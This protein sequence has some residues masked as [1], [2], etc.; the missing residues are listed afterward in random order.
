MSEFFTRSVSRRRGHPWFTDNF[1]AA[2]SV[3]RKL[4]VKENSCQARAYLTE[5]NVT[6]YLTEAYLNH[7]QVEIAFRFC[8]HSGAGCP[9]AWSDGLSCRAGAT[10]TAMT[11]HG[12]CGTTTGSQSAGSGCGSNGITFT[13]SN[14]SF[15]PFG[16]LRSPN[17]N[18]N[19]TT[20]FDFE[21]VVLV[22]TNTTATLGTFTGFNTEN[23]TA[24]ATTLAGTWTSGDLADFLKE[25]S[26][27]G[28]KNPISAVLSST[29]TVDAGATGYTVSVYD[30][31]A[32]TFGSLTDPYFTFDGGTSLSTG[33]LVMGFL[34]CD[35]PTAGDKNCP[36]PTAPNTTTL[37]DTTANSSFILDSGGRVFPPI[38][39]PASLTLLGTALAGFGVV[40]RR[41]RRSF[42]D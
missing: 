15:S 38:P 8:Q 25:T 39:E 20:P 40:F 28:D 14:T 31:G 24:T 16:F 17:S 2:S 33:T 32:V 34:E 37:E 27:A 36:L 11:L 13:N 12:F 5:E 22:P 30:F 10:S 19:L 26:T 1:T 21:L 42:Q 6:A 4:P 7:V 18:N 35:T 3:A 23:A 41:R 29:Q 9:D